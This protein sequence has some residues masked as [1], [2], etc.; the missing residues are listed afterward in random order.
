L[1]DTNTT[2]EPPKVF[3][4]W[5]GSSVFVEQ[6]R[7]W[8]SAFIWLSAALLGGTLTWAFTAKLDQTISVRGQLQPAGSVKEIESPSSG[9]VGKVFI[10]DG[11]KVTVGD[12]LLTVE[13]EGLTSRLEALDQSIQLLRL[14]AKSLQAIISSGGDPE[15]FGPLPP[16]PPVADDQLANKMLAARNQTEQIRSQLRQLS[17]RTTSRQESLRL[18]ESMASDMKPLYEIG[19]LARNVYLEQLNNIQVLK[20]EISTLEGER[21]RIIGTTTSQLNRINREDINLHAQ[22]SEVKEKISYRTIKAPVSGTVFDLKA[23]PYSVVNNSEP[24]LKIVPANELQASVSIP[25]T[26]IGF[27]KVGQ[28]ASVAVDSFPSG[29]FGYIQGTVT[30]IGS[31]VLPPD[32]NSQQRYFPSTLTLQEQTV[33]AGSQTLNLQSGMGI[34]ANIKLRS[35]PAITILTDIFTRQMEGVKRFR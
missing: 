20:A 9:V 26:D 19:G 16:L 35:R 17:I 7:H 18:K 25:N 11:Q 1:T 2:N 30:R 3:K 34:T 23:A 4:A 6:G 13:A 12:A 33:Q 10:V 5:E 29:E 15:R 22:L 14:E 8:S 21:S 24:L 32:K 27:V 28:A 31:D